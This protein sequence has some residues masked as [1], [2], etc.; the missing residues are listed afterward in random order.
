MGKM[1]KWGMV[2]FCSLVALA[3]GLIAYGYAVM[4]VDEVVPKAPSK[5]EP[6]RESELEPE[7][8]S[9]E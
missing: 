2:L 8:P 6:E 5:R 4:P 7:K 9:T 3:A 1:L